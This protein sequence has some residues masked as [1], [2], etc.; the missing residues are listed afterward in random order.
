MLTDIWL[1][2][3]YE[4]HVYDGLIKRVVTNLATFSASSR[5]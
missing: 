3:N 4:L 1:M 5:L 2:K